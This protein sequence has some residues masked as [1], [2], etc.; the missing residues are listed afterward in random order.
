MYAKLLVTSYNKEDIEFQR[1]KVDI[2]IDKLSQLN[3][4]RL[5]LMAAGDSKNLKEFQSASQL[6][7]HK[8]F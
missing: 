3:A 4:A 7:K 5:L 2:E 6:S 1:F 8:I